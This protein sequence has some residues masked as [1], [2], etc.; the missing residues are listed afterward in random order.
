MVTSDFLFVT[1]KILTVGVKKKGTIELQ[2]PCSPIK[3]HQTN[4]HTLFTECSASPRP[5]M[6][7]TSHIVNGDN[8]D[9][10]CPFKAGDTSAATR[11][12]L[13]YN[14]VLGHCI[15]SPQCHFLLSFSLNGN[16]ESISF[17][18]LRAD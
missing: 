11:L 6:A 1:N 18:A 8:M 4:G 9:F 12:A 13:S 5:A 3:W 16:H 14:C 7:D 17:P 10:N 2:L 15:S